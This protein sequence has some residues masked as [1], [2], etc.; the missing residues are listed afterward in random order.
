MHLCIC[1]VW[2]LSVVDS[3]TF[4]L[5]TGP[6]LHRDI[7]LTNIFIGAIEIIV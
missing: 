5:L 7:K 3:I 1:Q 4:K 6:Q 2:E